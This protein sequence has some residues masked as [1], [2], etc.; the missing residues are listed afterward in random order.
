[1][2]GTI[3]IIALMPRREA[4]PD[5]TMNKEQ[6]F[7]AIA[8]IIAQ[9]QCLRLDEVRPAARFEEDLHADSLDA[10]ELQMLFEEEF[11]V[12]IPDDLLRPCMETGDFTVAQ[13][14]DL[15]H[16]CINH[17]PLPEVADASQSPQNEG[18]A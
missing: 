4:T 3:R 16:A 9:E 6:I 2:F 13:A 11:G 18:G 17:L 5:T 15:L 7:A 12:E 14:V 1:M 8:P 10:V